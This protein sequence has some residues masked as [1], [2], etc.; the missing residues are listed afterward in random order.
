MLLQTFNM[1]H[2]WYSE[3]E[4][5]ESDANAN[6]YQTYDRIRALYLF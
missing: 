3:I 4:N 5:D 6:G 2:W 1:L